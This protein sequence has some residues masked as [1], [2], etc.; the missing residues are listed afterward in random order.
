VIFESFVQVTANVAKNNKG[1]VGR[2]PFRRLKEL[3][4]RSQMSVSNLLKPSKT[5]N[6]SPV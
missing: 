2:W 6:T 1:Q 5:S 3:S 4:S